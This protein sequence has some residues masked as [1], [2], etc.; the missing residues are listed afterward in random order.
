MA[1]CIAPNPGAGPAETMVGTVDCFMQSTVQSAYANLVGPGSNFG[2]ALTIALTLYVAIVGFRLILGRSSLSMGDMVPRMLLIGALLAITSSWATYQTLVY[3]VLTG[4][5]EDVAAM[6]IPSSS[7]QAGLTA[8]VDT[9]STRMVELAD[10]WTEF[11]ARVGLQDASPLPAAMPTAPATPAAAAPSATLGVP[12]FMGPRDSLGPNMLLLSA[13]LLVLGSAGVLV[14]AKIILGLLL[15]LGPAF[16][17]FALFGATRGLALGWARAA[18]MMALV[19]LLAMMTSAGAVALLEPLLTDMIVAAG[20]GIFSLRS[21]LTILAVV[22]LMVAVSVQ[23]LRVG[24]TIVGGWEWP[25]ARSDTQGQTLI[26]TASSDGPVAQSAPPFNER[27]QS[28]VGS[29][30]RSAASN[31]LIAASAQRAILLPP[32][33]DQDSAQPKVSNM[34]PDRRIAYRKAMVH[35]GPIKPFRSAA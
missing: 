24:R 6:V 11:D 18:F 10:A 14:L 13:L 3:D 29:I 23:L 19:P 28:L 20:Q 30:E 1:A 4:G 7:Q 32:R 33:N 35:R 25:W 9:L 15:A 16:A 31:P 12:A 21:A 27:I 34:N 17:A 26:A 2:Y 5:P 8:R 22:I